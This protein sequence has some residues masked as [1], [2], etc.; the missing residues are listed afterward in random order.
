MNCDLIIYHISKIYTVQ[1][2]NALRCG[3]E[4]SD[5]EVIENGYVAVND[6]VIIEVS[7]GDG[8]KEYIGKKT[9]LVDAGGLIMTP[10]LVD[11]HTHLVHA[12]SREHELKLKLMGKSYLDILNTGGGI[13]NTVNKT[14][15]ASFSELY[16]KAKKS[17]DIMLSYGV[18][19]I[20]AKSGYGLELETEL[21]QLEVAKKLDENHPVDIKSTFLG[22]HAYPL[23]Y[24]ENK[25]EYIKKVIEMLPIIKKKNLAEYCDVFCEEGVFSLEESE[26]ILNEAKKLGFKLKIHADEIEPLG[27]GSLACKLGCVSADHLMA[28]TIEDYRNL[29]KYKVVANLLP[30]TSFNLNKDY[31][32]ARCMID[33]N[34]GVA[35]SSDYNPGSCPSENLQFV[36]QL[37]CLK[38]KMLPEEVLTALTINGA[39]AINEETNIGSIEKG[40]RG[41]F[42]LFDAPNLEYLIYH[43]GINH[44]KDVYKN[45]KLVVSNQKIVY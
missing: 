19:T 27:G 21:K 45:G 38:M 15:E 36:G 23:E 28:S 8:Y 26:F 43:F 1:G 3:K 40:K 4:M 35:L 39:C 41:D 31:A 9:E 7:S 34:C 18:T 20:E 16:D 25:P 14:R 29:A 12:G 33:N 10:G 24:K 30:A 22:A 11:S 42:V 32:K 5:V 2:K 37:A 17:L 6:G 44:V 13:L